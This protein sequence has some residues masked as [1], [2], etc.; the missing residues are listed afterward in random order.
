MQLDDKVFGDF[1]RHTRTRG[2][3]SIQNQVNFTFILVSLTQLTKIQLHG[4]GINGFV[5]YLAYFCVHG[6]PF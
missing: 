2:K 5:N 6:S 4:L 1:P 3:A